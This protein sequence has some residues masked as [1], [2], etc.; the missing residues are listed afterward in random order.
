MKSISKLTA[1]IHLWLGLISGIIVF[2]IA[3][4][5]CLYAFKEEIENFTDRYKVV[6]F[7][8]KVFM[9]P[10]VLLKNAERVLTD[11]KIHA[12]LYQGR[13][14]TA[15]VIFFNNEDKYYY[16]VYLNPY[17]GDVLHIQD[18]HKGFFPFILEGHF[19]LWLPQ[20]IGQ[21]VVASATLVFV[22]MI[23]SGLYL[24]WKR[25]K[26]SSGQRFKIKLNTRW[27]RKNYDLHTI[28]G[29]YISALAI[30]FAITGLV[31]GFEWFKNG[32]YATISGGKDFIPYLEPASDSTA[33]HSISNIIPID[34]VWIKMLKEYPAMNAIELHPPG[35]LS[36]CI[37]ANANPDMSTYWKT[38]YL[39]FDQYSL[40][41]IP[42][43]HVW[44]RF[45]QLTASEKLM[46]MNYDIHTGAV[47]G[48]AGKFLVFFA[49]LTCATLPVTGFLIWWGRK[50]K[51]LRKPKKL[52][53]QIQNI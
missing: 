15:Q 48:L 12:V 50:K 39:Y 42:V 28:F 6:E 5:G 44:K 49:S 21:P 47:L 52:K 43:N 35:T 4:T 45:N 8:N 18:M 17:T 29:F 22:F 7:Q 36:S 11:K 38:D 46:R 25:K 26:G 14:R 10:S 34:K 24:W 2:I 40:K 1:K 51:E 41:E 3:V 16:T 31:W 27:R 33:I 13:E 53:L 19:Y 30:M 20:E 23:F 37:A 32:Y 9:P